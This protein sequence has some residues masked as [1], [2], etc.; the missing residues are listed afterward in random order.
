MKRVN[1]SDRDRRALKILGLCAVVAAGMMLGPRVLAPSPG[2]ETSIEA[3]E[4]RYLLARETAERQP[5]LE[6]DARAAARALQVLERRLLRSETPSLAQAEIRSVTTGLLRAEGIRAP[7]S[8]FGAAAMGE[9]LYTRIPIDLEFSCQ[10]EQLVR[11]MASLAN[12]A[13]ILS[14][15]RLKVTVDRAEARRIRVLLTVEGYLKPV[16][17]GARSSPISGGIG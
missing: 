6:R 11:F 10:P 16:R 12:A 14:T 4:Q 1:L 8:T 2:L 5:R 9:E 3:L 7:R 13:P 15:R 17:L